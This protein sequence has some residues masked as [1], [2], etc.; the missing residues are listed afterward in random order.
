M[1][2]TMKIAGLILAATM[3][4]GSF[5][6]CGKKKTASSF[7]ENGNFVPGSMLEL[8]VW[9]TQGTDYAP[10]EVN[11]NDI[12][13]KWLK[14]KTQVTVKNMY[15]NDGGQWDT[16]LT[17]LVAGDNLPDIVHCGGYQGP[18]HFTKLNELGKVWQL[19]PEILQKYAPDVWKN[20]PE[21][22]WEKM[23]V[24]GKILGIPYMMS[25][26]DAIFPYATEEEKELLRTSINNYN[27][28]TFT[29]G[30]FFWIRDDI[31]KDFY[32]DAK[33]YSELE[34]R[35]AEKGAPLEDE[36]LDIPIYS[37]E[38]FIDFMYKL[39][40]AGYTEEGKKVYPFGYCG[41]T[42]N[43]VALS[44][45]GA[46]MYGY[47]NHFY[48]S[49]WNNTTQRIEIPLVGDLMR[50][51]AKTQNQMV[52][53]SVIDPESLAHTSAQYKEKVL[54][55]QYAIAGL[56]M[57][58]RPQDINEEL[59][60]MGKSYRYRPFI[61]Q[62]PAH[63]DYP[64]FKERTYWAESVCLL[65]TLSEDELYQTL[66]WINTQ[67]TD[68]YAKIR[69][70]GTEES[71]LYEIGE[72][73]KPKFKDDRFNKYFIDGDSTA[74]PEEKDRMG[75]GGKGGLIRITPTDKDRWDPSIVYN[76]V[77]MEMDGG[78][79]FAFTSESEHVKNVEYCPPSNVWADIYASIPEVVE[80][81]SAREQWENKFKIAF[82]A[83]SEAEFDKK[84]D[85]AIADLNKIVNI[86]DLEDAMTKVA[87]EYVD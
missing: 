18:A 80:Y 78:T 7:D 58:G 87:K 30:Q 71:G 38:E 9:E 44:W 5:S 16:K 43:W 81:W 3:V 49:T 52:R 41:G 51:A 86:K 60:K 27:D 10:T 31:L 14:D 32:P 36:I 53:D 46:D 21:E 64:A 6:G 57:L 59:E 84:W 48:T 2:K 62:V 82:T 26:K 50:Q 39:K 20:T 56:T 8:T 13:A 22:Y 79:A 33:D 66:N 28:V 19:T 69:H 61:T 25:T 11:D 74:L 35:V 70:W 54:N 55:G 1:K 15:G 68:E 17:K 24:D 47:K 42:D 34:A 40:D 37:T 72:D 67:Y 45:L 75:L 76:K 77:N 63:E 4:C 12:V 85:A 29:I 23:S 65:N 83:E 73:G